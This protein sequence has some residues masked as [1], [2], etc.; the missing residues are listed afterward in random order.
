MNA[1]AT[2]RFRLVLALACWWPSYAL[3]GY[4]GS[5][6]WRWFAVETFGAHPITTWQAA[7]VIALLHFFLPTQI[8]GKDTLSE[9]RVE[10]IA[11]ALTYGFL[12]PLFTFASAALIHGV[13]L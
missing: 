11:L 7:G 2:T 4:L 13:M 6:V 3:Q 10:V 1:T 5:I 9:T 12:V 8:R